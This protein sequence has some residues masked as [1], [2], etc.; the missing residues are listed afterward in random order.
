VAPADRQ[1]IEPFTIPGT[2][3]CRCIFVGHPSG[4]AWWM[5]L[6]GPHAEVGDLTGY[7]KTPDLGY[8]RGDERDVLIPE[9]AG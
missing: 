7:I 6:R 2:Y 5:I 4:W 3:F 9:A 1:Y 8:R